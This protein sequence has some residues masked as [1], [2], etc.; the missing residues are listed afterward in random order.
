[1]VLATKDEW[2][3]KNSKGSRRKEK[4]LA[5]KNITKLFFFL[6]CR[7]DFSEIHLIPLL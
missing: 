1:M 2:H 3:T 4:N 6:L 7:Y 5:D